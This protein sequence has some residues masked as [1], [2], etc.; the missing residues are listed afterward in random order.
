MLGRDCLGM[1]NV[2]HKCHLAAVSPDWW[3]GALAARELCESLLGLNQQAQPRRQACP[4]KRALL[5]GV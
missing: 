2:S 4:H 3:A 1:C 5:W